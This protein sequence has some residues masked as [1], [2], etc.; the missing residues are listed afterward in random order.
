[1]LIIYVNSSKAKEI[2]NWEPSVTF[3]DLVKIM[4]ESDLDRW[5]AFQ[6]GRH[7]PWD[8]LNYPT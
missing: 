2:L 5:K 8:A 4:V 1:M 6:E 3:D 7:I